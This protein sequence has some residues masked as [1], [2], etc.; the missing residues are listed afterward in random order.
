MT[1]PFVRLADG[2]DCSLTRPSPRC[3]TL[4]NIAHGLAN[5]VRFNG[6]TRR[7]ITVAEHCVVASLLVPE[8]HALAALLHDAAEIV[9]GDIVRPVRRALADG[10][11]SIGG[12][13]REIESRLNHAVAVHWHLPSDFAEHPVVQKIDARLLAAEARDHLAGGL[14]GLGLP[15]DLE[16]VAV[17]LDGWPAEY[18]ERRF[19]DRAAEI[20]VADRSRAEGL[21]IDLARP[22]GERA[23][24]N[25]VDWFGD[26]GEA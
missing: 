26:G 13:L 19:L 11:P 21:A 2:S 23:A 22:K 14:D 3:F 5:T 18:A 12:G 15:G 24:R 7:P 6:A 4:T 17:T 16:P 20:L 9:L 1:G 10:H 8:D 25:G